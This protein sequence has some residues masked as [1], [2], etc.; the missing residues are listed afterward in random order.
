MKRKADGTFE[1]NQKMLTDASKS[2]AALHGSA[3]PKIVQH[4]TARALLAQ[5][6]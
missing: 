4:V 5:A 1:E 6:R 3:N 2:L